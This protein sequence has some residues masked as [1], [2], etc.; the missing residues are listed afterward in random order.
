MAETIQFTCRIL[1]RYIEMHALVILQGLEVAETMN[2]GLFA[3]CKAAL[4]NAEKSSCGA[5]RNAG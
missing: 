3:V 2:N 4:N 5:V 1:G